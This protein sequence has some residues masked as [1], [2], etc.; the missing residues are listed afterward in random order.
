MN[1]NA[2]LSFKAFDDELNSQEMRPK[3]SCS[4][5]VS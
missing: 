5:A 4:L 3:G 1:H 2:L